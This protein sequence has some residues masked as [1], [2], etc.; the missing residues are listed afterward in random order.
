MG[1]SFGALCGLGL[2]AWLPP[3]WD[4]QP[5]VYSIIC[6]TAMLGGVF[7]SSISLVVIVVEGTKGEP[8]PQKSLSASATAA[9]FLAAAGLR[10]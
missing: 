6:A 4:I 10:P 9:V 1:S 3:P 5:G 8:L 2:Q 7:R